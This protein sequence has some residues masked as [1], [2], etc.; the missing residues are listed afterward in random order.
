MFELMDTFFFQYFFLHSTLVAESIVKMGILCLLIKSSRGDNNSVIVQPA[1]S[2][3][4]G[5]EANIKRG[6][7]L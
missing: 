6:N 3:L 7:T 2:G 4:L 1:S 5:L